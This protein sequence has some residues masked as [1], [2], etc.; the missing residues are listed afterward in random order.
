MFSVLLINECYSSEERV[1]FE[2]AIIYLSVPK[3][4]DAIVTERSLTPVSSINPMIYYEVEAYLYIE[5]PIHTSIDGASV[6]KVA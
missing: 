1:E 4:G 3:E 6:Q 2:Y 5:R